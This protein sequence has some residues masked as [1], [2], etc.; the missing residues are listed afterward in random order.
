MIGYTYITHTLYFLHAGNGS[1][2]CGINL[3][4][5]IVVN[6]MYQ[7]YQTK[8]ENDALKTL[9]SK[10]QKCTQTHVYIDSIS[11][12]FIYSYMLHS[13]D[14]KGN[15]VKQIHVWIG[16]KRYDKRVEICKEM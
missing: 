12:Y 4:R 8:N 1:D 3:G 16:Y 11:S 9:K 15:H 7:L 14:G 2:N 6:Y 5:I 10:Q 13:C